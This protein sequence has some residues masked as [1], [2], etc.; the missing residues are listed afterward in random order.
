MSCLY[1]CCM[2]LLGRA[3]GSKIAVPR[4]LGAAAAPS[5]GGGGAVWRVGLR[6][7]RLELLPRVTPSR[8]HLLGAL[9]NSDFDRLSPHLRL[10]SLS[11]G[12]ALYESGVTPQASRSHP[13]C[14][15]P[16]PVSCQFPP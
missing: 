12:E 3:W 5:V 15:N 7:D 16:R 8:N 2:Q 13:G 10:V 11:L 14:S 9:P 6:A 1:A 4:T